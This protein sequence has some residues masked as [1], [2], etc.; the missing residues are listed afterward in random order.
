MFMESWTAQFESTVTFTFMPELYPG[1]R[2][3][4]NI[5]NETGGRDQYQFYVTDVTHQGSR[6]AG[7]TTEAVLT[8]PMKN[9]ALLHYGLDFIS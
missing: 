8:A 7:F 4:I 9:G 1:M 6:S 3:V 2:I 5:D